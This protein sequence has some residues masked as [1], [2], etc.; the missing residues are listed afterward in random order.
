M[1]T[2]EPAGGLP[3]TPGSTKANE[4]ANMPHKWHPDIVMRLTN[5]NSA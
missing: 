1:G 2:A 5:G 4:V 3:L